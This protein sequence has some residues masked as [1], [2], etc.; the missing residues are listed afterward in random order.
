M[1]RT[2]YGRHGGDDGDEM[3]APVSHLG[4]IVGPICMKVEAHRDVKLYRLWPDAR[5]WGRQCWRCP[6]ERGRAQMGLYR[7][8]AVPSETL[9]SSLRCRLPLLLPPSPRQRCA[10]PI[11]RQGIGGDFYVRGE[12]GELDVGQA[13][14][15]SRDGMGVGVCLEIPARFVFV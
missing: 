9:R 5:I 2:G 3:D 13:S 11:I 7:P 14:P 10:G 15:T 4:G 1:R 8:Q 6:V 12:L